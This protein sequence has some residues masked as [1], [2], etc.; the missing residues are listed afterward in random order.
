LNFL[1]LS[2]YKSDLEDKLHTYIKLNGVL[3]RHF[4]KQTTKATKLRIHS[5]KHKV[6]LKFSS[7]VWV[8][9]ERKELRMEES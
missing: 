2:E 4:G 1:L 5:I 6:A 9:K 8:L 7:K 3:L